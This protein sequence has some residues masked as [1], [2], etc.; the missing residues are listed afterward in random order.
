MKLLIN[1]MA[2]IQEKAQFVLW[3]YEVKFLIKVQRH[4]QNK[5]KKD[6]PSIKIWLKL[7]LEIGSIENQKSSHGPETT[8]DSVDPIQGLFQS[9]LQNLFVILHKLCIYVV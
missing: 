8:D 7:F 5:Y 2:P 3:L 1:K 9:S 4:Y 6:A